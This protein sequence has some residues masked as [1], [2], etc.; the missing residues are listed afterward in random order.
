MNLLLTSAGFRNSSMMKALKELTAKDLASSKITV[1]LTA[2]VADDANKSWLIRDLNRIYELKFASLDIL[3]IASV[4]K[5]NWLPR[6]VASDI[7]YVAGGNPYH[8][9][10]CAIRTGFAETLPE[11]LRTRVYVGESAG[12][13]LIGL[14]LS[15]S[16]N[17]RYVPEGMSL[18]KPIAGLGL[19]DFCIRSHFNNPHFALASESEI[20]QQAHKTKLPVYAID[21]QTA[22]KM[23]DDK[24]EIVGNGT[25]LKLNI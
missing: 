16:S 21:D 19:V 7:I 9:L 4:P 22:I 20:R 17:K 10:D 8:L 3:D 13:A 25:Y 18:A 2:S 1:I 12:S 24:L 5:R 14:S 15:Y 11:L 6:L 23:I